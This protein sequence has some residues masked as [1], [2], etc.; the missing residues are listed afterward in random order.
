MALVATPNPDVGIG[1]RKIRAAI[2]IPISM[3]NWLWLSGRWTMPSASSRE[4]SEIVFNDV[5]LIPMRADQY[6][7]AMKA[8]T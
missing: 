1:Q 6:T 8:K 3:P 2:Q 7:L 4:L 5:A